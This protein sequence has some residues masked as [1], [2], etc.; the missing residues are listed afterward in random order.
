[1][2]NPSKIYDTTPNL[3][4]LKSQLISTTSKNYIS[5]NSHPIVYN[6]LIL[7]ARTN[8]KKVYDTTPNLNH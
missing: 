1:M 2:I 8:P 6:F 5:D 4:D 7:H 3:N